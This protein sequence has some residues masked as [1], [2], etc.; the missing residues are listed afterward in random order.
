MDVALVAPDG[1]MTRQ[2]IE[3]REE[4]GVFRLAA[5]APPSQV[6]L[7]PEGWV[8]WEDLTRR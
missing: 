3:I 7:D 8:L 6:V 4:E 5:E 1:T 2:R